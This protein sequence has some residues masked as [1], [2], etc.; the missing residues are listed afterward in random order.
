VDPVSHAAF[1][2]TAVRAWRPAGPGVGLA[3]SIGALAPDLDALFMPFGWDVYLRVHEIGTHSLLGG[4]VVALAAAI[5]VR[6]R[7]RA[8]LPPLF[9]ITCLAVM[10]HLVLDIV[11]GARLQLGWPLFDVRIVA[12]LAAMAEPWLLAG[13]VLAVGAMALANAYAQRIARLALIAIA[14]CLAVKGAWLVQALQTLPAQ[15]KRPAPRRVVEAQWGTMR[16]WTVFSRT[17]TDLVRTSIAPHRSPA[18]LDMWP[19]ASDFPLA[20]PSRRLGTVRNFKAIH[21]I[22]F[23]REHPV[24]DGGTEVLWSD[25]RF[26]WRPAAGRERAD[27]RD[28][29]RRWPLTLGS[30]SA[31]IACALWVGG[32]FDRAGRAINERVQ[33]FG[34]WQTRAAR[35]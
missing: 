24:A 20:A 16:Q 25:L 3:A 8:A 14:V 5:A 19:I 17:A 22:T 2:Y 11:S 27:G 18:T 26:C 30:G 31:Q 29:P 9:A 28:E 13:C 4:V 23:A 15:P 32:T 7:S 6:V 34:L 12:P 21:E 10:S 1:G 35:P 33:V